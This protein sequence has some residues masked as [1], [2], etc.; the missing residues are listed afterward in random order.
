M[1]LPKN[2]ETPRGLELQAKLKAALAADPSFKDWPMPTKEDYVLIGGI[3]V[4]YSYVEFNL[5]R[6]AEAFDHS[7][8][9]PPP[10]KGRAMNLDVDRS[11]R[12]F[13]RPRCGQGQ[14]MSRR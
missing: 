3:V 2:V 9:L 12:L 8:L 11:N 5:R 6:L 14:P 7:G 1:S 10:W 4:L 13:K